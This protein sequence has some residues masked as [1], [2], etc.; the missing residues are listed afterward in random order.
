[1][2]MSYEGIN[3]KRVAAE[4]WDRH[5]IIVAAIDRQDFKGIRV[6]PHVYTTHSEIDR[7]CEVMEQ[8]IGGRT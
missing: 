7:F 1:M 5:R 6:S 8:V 4:L 2:T 3:P